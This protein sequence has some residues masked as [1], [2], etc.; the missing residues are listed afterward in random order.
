[1]LLASS[2]PITFSK[3]AFPMWNF[4]QSCTTKQFLS[5]VANHSKTNFFFYSKLSSRK[6]G[7]SLRVFHRNSLKYTATIGEANSTATGFFLLKIVPREKPRLHAIT[8]PSYKQPNKL[9][10]LQNTNDNDNEFVYS[11]K[12]IGEYSKALYIKLN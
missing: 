11:A 3:I 1:M 6:R 9:S 2:S 7:N 4:E 10:Q 5:V 12:T 8:A